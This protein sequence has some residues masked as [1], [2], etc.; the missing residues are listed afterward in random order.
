MS[1]KAI[2][3]VWQNSKQKGGALLV[4]LAIADFCDDHGRAWPAV[5]TLANKA[6][7]TPRNVNYIIEEKLKPAGLTVEKNG[8]P[9]RANLYR[10][11]INLEGETDFRVKSFQGE[12]HFTKRV[13]PISP[14]P[15][16]NRHKRESTE[17]DKLIPD[18]LTPKSK[19]KLTRPDAAQVRAFETWYAA[20]PKRVG[21]KPALKAWLKLDPDPVLVETIMT[22]TARYADLKAGVEARFVL[23]PA[24]WINQE[25]WTDETPISNGNG[26]AKP[27]QVTELGNGMVEVDGVQMDRRIYERR[28]GQ[29][30]S[31]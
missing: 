30:A 12:A 8:G 22:A 19:R 14:N 29:H 15:S 23:D 16:L 11:S 9:H 20:Y 10:L 27:V 7:M 17:S 5:E 6:R 25:R 26:H 24:T 2:N 1:I 13:K 28:H 3:W 18:S 31:A 4:E 21:K